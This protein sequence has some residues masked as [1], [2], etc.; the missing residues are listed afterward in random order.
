MSKELKYILDD[1]RSLLK[2]IADEDKPEVRKILLLD[3]E[4]KLKSFSKKSVAKPSQKEKVD[5]IIFTVVDVEQSTLNHLLNFENPDEAYHDKINNRKIWKSEL[6]RNGRSPLSL[7]ITQI[8]EAGPVKASVSC[9]RIFEKYDCNLAVLVGIAAGNPSGVPKYSVI[10][11]EGVVD[12]EPQRL[13]KGKTTYRSIPYPLKPVSFANELKNFISSLSQKRWKGNFLK[14]FDSFKALYKT[15]IDLYK[16]EKLSEFD[17]LLKD[18]KL[19]LGIIG[20]GNKLIADGETLRTLKEEIAF[21]K[22]IVAAEM[23]AAGFCPACEEFDI[24]WIMFRGISDFGGDDK[25]DV[26]NK[27]FQWVA[28]LTGITAMLEYLKNDYSSPLDSENE[29]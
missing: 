9:L 1:C 16:S 10:I 28:A 27:K 2:F 29:F 26:M 17:E 8:G 3:A 5:I 19:E 6:K 11:S 20:S 14:Q 12:Y 7:L 4:D 18:I 23:E 15:D 22:G 21:K 24:K 13:E 25:D